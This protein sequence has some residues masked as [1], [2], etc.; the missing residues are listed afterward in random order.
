[1]DLI[2]PVLPRYPLSHTAFFPYSISNRSTTIPGTR[3]HIPTYDIT[4]STQEEH[5]LKVQCDE[6][7]SEVKVQV[8]EVMYEEV[9]VQRENDGT[10][11]QQQQPQALATIYTSVPKRLLG[12]SYTTSGGRTSSVQ[13]EHPRSCLCVSSL[14]HVFSNFILRSCRLPCTVVNNRHV[15]HWPTER[16][17]LSNRLLGISYLSRYRDIL[18]IFLRRFIVANRTE[19]HQT[20][21]FFEFYLL[22]STRRQTVP[23]HSSNVRAVS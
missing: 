21:L 8:G 18:S 4:S 17:Q 2:E 16:H 15:F 14:C 10:R 22:T 12:I 13:E 23:V 20:V 3:Y 9:K 1:M 11:E 6:V 5:T 7:M 19:K